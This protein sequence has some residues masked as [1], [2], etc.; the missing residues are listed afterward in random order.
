MS[1]NT[2]NAKSKNDQFFTIAQL[3]REL[4]VNPKI[5]RRRMRVAIAKNDDRVVQSRK[6]NVNDDARVKHEF[7]IKH[8][9]RIASIITND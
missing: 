8:R 5:A 2:N 7:N 4:N 1:K 3:S 6:R 9:D